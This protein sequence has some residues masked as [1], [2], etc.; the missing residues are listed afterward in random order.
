MSENIA[1]Q[2]LIDAST[3]ANNKNHLQHMDLISKRVSLQG[4]PGFDNIDYDAWATQ[5]KHEFENNLL[6]SVNYQGL[7]LITE[8]KSHIMF[9][10]YE[11]V[12]GA[13]GTVNKQGVEMLLEKEDDGKWRLVQER[14]LAD[15]ETVHDKLLPE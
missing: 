10:T 5:C 11:T 7:K 15:A 4:V 1:Q 2:W 8:T 12:E 13:D 14:V 9:K 6:K 3:T